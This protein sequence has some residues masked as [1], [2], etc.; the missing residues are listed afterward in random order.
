MR[1]NNFKLFRILKVSIFFVSL[2]YFLYFLFEYKNFFSDLTIFSI[3]TLLTIFVLKIFN[4]VFLSNINLGILKNLNINLTQF[5]SLDVTNKNTLGNLTS[6]FKLGTG[7]KISYL[8]SHFDINIKDYIIVSTLYGLLNLIPIVII[9]C[10]LALVFGE[11]SEI[12]NYLLSL[13]TLLYLFFC[14]YLLRG[15]LISKYFKVVSSLEI[16][17]KNNLFIQIN[18]VLF[19]LNTSVIVWI[20]INQINVEKDFLSAIA[21]TSVGSFVNLVNITPGNIG[22]QESLLILFKNLHGLNAYTIVFVSFLER[23]M[24]LIA[25]FIFQYVL[26]KKSKN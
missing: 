1:F 24:S 4:I 5:E 22:V 15:K 12:Y 7:Y 13:V 20:I 9:F 6:P 19:F 16:F 17:N 18:N 8:K 11:L 2:I 14:I 10:L 3:P 25:L 26:A 21:Y 23:L